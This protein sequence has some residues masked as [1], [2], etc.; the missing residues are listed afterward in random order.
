MSVGARFNT[1]NRT[2]APRAPNG[3]TGA[4][5]CATAHGS[6]RKPPVSVVLAVPRAYTP[7]VRLAAPLRI[8]LLG[9][10]AMALQ[11]LVVRELCSA[12]TGNEQVVGIVLGPWLMATALGAALGRWPPLA[13]YRSHRATA[14]LLLTLGPLSFLTLLAARL[15]PRLFELGSSPDFGTVLM[16]AILVV[17]PSCM[18]SGLLYAWLSQDSA[19]HRRRG[20]AFAAD[21][22]GA[23]VLAALLGTAVVGGAAPFAILGAVSLTTTLAAGFVLD[24]SRVLVLRSQA[25][26]AAAGVA[27]AIACLTLPLDDWAT[28]WSMPGHGLEVPRRVE[29]SHGAI[30]LA[31]GSVLVDRHVVAIPSDRIAAAE[32][33]HVPLAYTP[34]PKR[35]AI[36]GVPPVGTIGELFGW[37]SA[38]S[39]GASRTSPSPM[40][41]ANSL[42]TF[43]GPRSRWSSA[44]DVDFWRTALKSSMSCFWPSPSRPTPPKTA[45]SPWRCSERY[46]GPWPP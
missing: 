17:L 38:A 10:A 27:L 7:P 2:R 6:T 41:C 45:S 12:C 33:A 35:V 21:S 19:V 22:L 37:G 15:L 4:D 44:T 24:R 20:W 42:T 34:D 18:V 3:Q 14:A 16:A 30:T 46:A 11:T 39:T 32:T 40:S 28:G 29:S 36:L 9:A 1:A 23:T 43:E 26:L 13:R 5:R 8:C 25:A 31:R